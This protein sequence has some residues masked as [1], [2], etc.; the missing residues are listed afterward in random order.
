MFKNRKIAM[1]TPEEE[2]AINRGIAA[3]PD[4]YELTEE[5]IRQMKPFGEQAKRVER[6]KLANS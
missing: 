2:E 6:P 5:E 3:D 1:P 4:T